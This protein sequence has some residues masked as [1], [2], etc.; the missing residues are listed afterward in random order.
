MDI[1]ICTY[2]RPNRQITY[3]NLPKSIQKKV[4]FVVQKR[5]AHRWAPDRNLVVLPDRIQNLPDTREW[6]KILNGDSNKFVMMDDDLVFAIRRTDDPTK[7][8]SYPSVLDFELLFSRIE[9]NLDTYAHVGVSGRE[10]GNRFVADYKT[11]GRMMRV[12]AYRRDILLQENI[13]MNRLPD[14]EDFDVTLQLL[15]LEYPNLIINWMVQNQSGSDA[16]GGCSEYR[17]PETH[18]RDCKLL[19]EFHPGFVSVVKK[20]TKTAWG[21]GERTDVRIQWRKAFESAGAIRLLDKRKG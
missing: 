11:V 20:V 8:N 7:F 1:Y 9:S 3:D 18:D 16:R 4:W 5:E 15:R 13:K 19:A 12:L 14:V 10:G 2:G 21:G 17:T 6:L